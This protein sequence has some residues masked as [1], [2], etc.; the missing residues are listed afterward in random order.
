MSTET[1][2]P[3]FFMHKDWGKYLDSF[4][5][6]SLKKID[7]IFNKRAFESLADIIF[8]SKRVT[9]TS[10]DMKKTGLS[11]IIS[12]L[13][14]LPSNAQGV[15]TLNNYFNT[16]AHNIKTNNF[17]SPKTNVS[18]IYDTHYMLASQ[19]GKML[20]LDFGYGWDE[21]YGYI[22]KCELKIDLSSATFYTGFWTRGYTGKGKWEHYGKKEAITIEDNNG[23]DLTYTG[24]QNYN[25]GTKQNIISKIVISF[26]SEPLANR[27][28]N[29]LYSIQ[30]PYKGKEPWLL[31][32]PE[33]EQQK[34]E[35]PPS[36]QKKVE[37]KSTG[38]KK[39]KSSNNT[40]GT[41]EKKYGKYGQ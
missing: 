35:T 8:C 33:P 15:S 7:F 9:G 3:R 37:S 2:L 39:A 26:G 17:F 12:L 19:L 6:D 27:V 29:E 16:Y 24:E 41:T 13:M 23:M 31:P 22:H 14:F 38:T 28:L 4:N 25:R 20:T 32:Q 40:K 10:N 21:K 18:C 36:S 34:V 1:I 30:S 11:L 5:S